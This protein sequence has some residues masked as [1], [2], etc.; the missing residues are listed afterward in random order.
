ML[1]N[2]MV[3]LDVCTFDLMAT[4]MKGGSSEKEERVGPG[5]AQT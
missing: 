4:L 5:M 3:R 2:K 1:I